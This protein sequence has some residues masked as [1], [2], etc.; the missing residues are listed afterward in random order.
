[1]I[2]QGLG[3]LTLNRVN[4]RD[5]NSALIRRIYLSGELTPLRLYIVVIDVADNEAPERK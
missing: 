4:A 3:A 2:D 5:N 1:M